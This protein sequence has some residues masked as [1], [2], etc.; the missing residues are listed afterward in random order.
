MRTSLRV[1]S[2]YLLTLLFTIVS[3]SED[4]PVESSTTGT[5]S[6][7]IIDAIKNSTMAN[8]NVFS[9]P[10]TSFVTTDSNGQYEIKNVN[11]GEYEMFATKAE[12]DSMTVNISVVAGANTISDFSMQIIDSSIY[13]I[14]GSIRG[15]VLNYKDGYPIQNANIRTMPVTA[16]IITDQDGQFLLPNITVGTYAIY[17]EKANFETANISVAVEKELVT[18]ADVFLTELDTNASKVYGSIKGTIKNSSDNSLLEN[19]SIRTVP[20]TSIVSTNIDGDYSI[21]N[22]TPG[23]YDI[24]AEKTNFEA[25]SISVVVVKGITTTADFFI[26]ELDTNAF[27]TTGNIVGRIIDAKTGVAIKEAV[28]T[29]FP[30]TSSV[31]SD[32]LGEYKIENLNP[33]EYSV[34]VSKYGYQSTTTTVNVVVGSDTKADISLTEQSTGNV[35][36]IVIDATTGN[37]IKGVSITT[38]PGTSSVTTDSLGSY[39]LV[40]LTPNNYDIIVDKI[41][42]VSTKVSV[43][44]IAEE[45]TIA[46]I[47]LLSE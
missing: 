20:A 44:V 29:T 30:A 27:I 12:F 46:D 40:N 36:G 37:P 8:V 18:T 4:S 7:V 33:A 39:Y 1:V 5:V 23:N 47:T 22:I 31:T 9:K 11:P 21:S 14:Y 28:I 6:G 13:N 32:Q 34:L 42:Y 41:G 26:N 3:C 38:E 17:A 16:S 43:L 24:Y 15:I 2:F 35:A 45:T 19:V 25:P 10:A